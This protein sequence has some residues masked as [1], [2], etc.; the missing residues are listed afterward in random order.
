MSKYRKL[1][2]KIMV[3]RQRN[4]VQ[5]WFSSRNNVSLPR[6]IWQCLKTFVVVPMGE[7]EKEDFYGH[8]SKKGQ[9]GC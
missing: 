8:L 7:R 1:V 4:I 5:Q 6:N 9:R 3:S 2:K